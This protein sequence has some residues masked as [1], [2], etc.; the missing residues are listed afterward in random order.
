MHIDQVSLHGYFFF[1][2]VCVCVREIYCTCNIYL[3]LLPINHVL[4]G[5]IIVTR[6]KRLHTFLEFVKLLFVKCS[7]VRSGT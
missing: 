4:N 7:E 6:W 1:L 2:I 3:C 5:K